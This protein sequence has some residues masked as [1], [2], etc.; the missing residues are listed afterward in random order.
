MFSP[1]LGEDA[2]GGDPA[3]DE[4]VELAAVLCG[5]DYAYLGRLDEKDLWFKS[6]Y[7]FEA[8]KQARA[9]TA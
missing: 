6:R 5:A 1:G 2:N 8:A 7:G 4:L 3:L 9:A